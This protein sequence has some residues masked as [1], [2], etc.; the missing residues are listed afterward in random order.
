ML[1]VAQSSS[2]YVAVCDDVL[3]S[4][5]TSAESSP[6]FETKDVQVSVEVCM[7]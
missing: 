3:S 2:R 5:S 4:G 6:S 1:Q 7:I